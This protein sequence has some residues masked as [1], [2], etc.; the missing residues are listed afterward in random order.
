MP[1]TKPTKEP[2]SLF[3]VLKE[4]FEHGGK[5]FTGNPASPTDLYAEFHKQPRTALCL[6]GGGVRS[7]TFSLGVL[8]GLARASCNGRSLLNQ[9]D[10]LSTVSGGG[11]AGS[12]LS[13]WAVNA[14]RAGAQDGPSQVAADLGA[15]PNVQGNP[16]QPPLQY[17][18]RYAAFLDPK[19]GLLSA[20]SWTLASIILRNL[21]LN[22]L[23]LVP[24]LLA[25]LLLPDI[26]RRILDIGVSAATNQAMLWLAAAMAAIA[27]AYIFY[28]LPSFYSLNRGK[29]DPNSGG[30]PGLFQAVA[31]LPLLMAAVLLSL[32]WAWSVSAKDPYHWW[33]FMLFGGGVHAGG[34][35]LAALLT[36]VRIRKPAL[37][38]FLAIL[39]A[40]GSGMV[41]GWLAYLA[42]G[43]FGRPLSLSFFAC[44]GV[45]LIV[46]SFGIAAMLGVGFASQITSDADRE[47][48]ARAGAWLLIVICGWLV[49]V[50][51]VL[52]GPALLM[53]GYRLLITATGAAATGGLAS[54]LGF[55]ASTSAGRNSG[56]PAS[57][58]N[59]PSWKDLVAKLA[60]PVFLILLVAVLAFSNHALLDLVGP[61][62]P[63]IPPTCLHITAGIGWLLI[64]FLSSWVL[65][66]NRFSL[67]AM[68][69]DRLVRTYLGAS[70][71][72]RS[73]TVNPF[74]DLDEADNVWMKDLSAHGPL[75]IVNIA[76]NLVSG[77]NLAWQQRK[78]ESFTV[79]RLHVGSSQLD[80]Q[81]GYQP[82][83]SYGG[84]HGLS[85]GSAIA[86]SGAA[87]S[88]NMG[89]HS[90]PA[91]TFVMTLFNA[92]LGWWLA[93][94]GRSGRGA[95]KKNGPTLALQPLLNEAFGRTNDK[96][97]WVYLS[98]GG[99][100][101]NLGIYEMVLRRC[102]TIV[103]VDASQDSE[104]DFEDLA[105]AVRK[106]RVDLGITIDFP[107]G[108][109]M[110]AKH[111]VRNRYVA[112]GRIYYPENPRPSYLLYVKPCLNG[113]EPVDVG[114]YAR[115]EPSFPQQGTEELWFNE[116]QFES[117]RRL[118]LHIVDQLLVKQATGLNA[119]IGAYLVGAANEY[120]EPSVVALEPPN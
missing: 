52:Y 91:L 109:M 30:G 6:S 44:L 75:H 113:S 9:F 48:W 103:V 117:Y 23:L 99:H 110:Y 54:K 26:Y 2:L 87:A 41:A 58:A 79:S 11:Y 77:D 63:W 15:R 17:L 4:E 45:P 104:Y 107:N 56:D 32:H 13:T 31:L 14:E 118:G 33:Q 119:P 7:A 18:R 22:W 72:A 80:G 73:R 74:I 60:G 86:I 78:A 57:A 34:T 24:L 96:S 49:A 37:K 82:T 12:W 39:I 42:S 28:Q 84:P 40:G 101:E 21:L 70:R 53:N 106:V 105:N 67:H 50:S 102:Q 81:Q 100:F 97:W 5:Q 66:V 68:Y 71:Q 25:V 98:D 108:L 59:M 43:F 83:I 94:P 92:R 65:N 8:Q 89:Y 90:S 19:I 29:D 116:S 61:E 27:T 20:D 10:F 38:P 76:L 64:A 112:V 55:S 1:A 95:W 85:L 88:P 46:A 47:W 62:F 35:L 114:T 120:L 69:R 51:I 115:E 16:E 111:D 36:S 93:N 3:T